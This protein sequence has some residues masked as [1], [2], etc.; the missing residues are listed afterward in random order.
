MTTP[1]I[2]GEATVGPALNVPFCATVLA[3]E[4]ERL[5]TYD[6]HADAGEL[7]SSAGTMTVMGPNTPVVLRQLGSDIR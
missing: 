4:H 1:V 3:L 6:R 5:A 7:A 2:P